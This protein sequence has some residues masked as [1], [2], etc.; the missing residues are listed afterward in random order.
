VASREFRQFLLT[1]ADR[2]PRP[3]KR[4]RHRESLGTHILGTLS[5]SLGL[6]AL[7]R[8]GDIWHGT[9]LISQSIS[10]WLDPPPASRTPAIPP[11]DPGFARYC[12]L[13]LVGQYLGIA[14]VWRSRKR[15]GTISLVSA[16]GLVACSVASSPIYLLTV[17]WAVAL[18]WPFLLGIA[19][20]ALFVQMIKFTLKS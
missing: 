9:L 5:L 1:L 12:G 13:A 10:V 17:G 19:A 2:R 11:F 4:P 15:Q 20:L 3:A 7:L 6:A 16:I 18:G 8:I 14:G